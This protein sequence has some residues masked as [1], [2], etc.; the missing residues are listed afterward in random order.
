MKKAIFLD[1][2][3]TLNNNQDQYYIWRPEDFR[4]NPGVAEALSEL[5]A[6]GYL[7]LVITNQG[8]VSKGEYSLEEVDALH[9]AMCS[10]LE[11]AGVK[12]EEIYVCPHHPDHAVWFA[13]SGHSHLSRERGYV[14]GC[15]GIRSGLRVRQTGWDSVCDHY[16]IDVDRRCS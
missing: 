12:L 14:A 5:Q 3:G 4:L 2:D 15:A 11:E 10:L 8:G 7:L 16:Y 13:W 9:A 6:R 1:R